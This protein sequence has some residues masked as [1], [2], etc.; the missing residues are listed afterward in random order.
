[1]LKNDL[2]TII[3]ITNRLVYIKMNT[4]QLLEVLQMSVGGVKLP[5]LNCFGNE[6]QY[7][8]ALNCIIADKINTVIDNVKYTIKEFKYGTNSLVLAVAGDR[9]QKL[10][11]KIRKGVVNAV[12]HNNYYGNNLV[13]KVID[14]IIDNFQVG[15]VFPK[16]RLCTMQ[17]R[18]T[19]NDVLI[20]EIGVFSNNDG[21][22]IDLPKLVTNIDEMTVL[23]C[24]TDYMFSA[25]QLCNVPD[26]QCCIYYSNDIAKKMQIKDFQLLVKRFQNLLNQRMIQRKHYDI[27]D[28]FRFVDYKL[29]FPKYV[30]RF[31]TDFDDE[32]IIQIKGFLRD[33]VTFDRLQELLMEVAL[34]ISYR[35]LVDYINYGV[36]VVR[37]VDNKVTKVRLKYN[38]S[39]CD[40]KNG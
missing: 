10:E 40:G 11:E 36:E 32:I 38:Y 34:F 7:L 24:D 8:S 12:T 9:V 25:M 18:R 30:C 35:K 17:E 16:I 1:M 23:L 33:F 27:K 4:T 28:Y 21:I 22:M 14:Y 6:V 26:D 31:V 3:L 29:K 20:K 15:V 2:L 37:I 5:F 19:I 13:Y 39:I